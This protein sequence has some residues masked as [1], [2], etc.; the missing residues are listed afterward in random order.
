[1]PTLKFLGPAPGSAMIR[2]PVR[3]RKT[4]RLAV[5]ENNR[6]DQTGS[7]V[8]TMINS[9][10]QKLNS[11]AL[12]LR[13]DWLTY[14]SFAS[15]KLLNNSNSKMCVC[16]C[17]SIN[18][19]EIDIINQSALSF[20]TKFRLIIF[21]N[22]Q[23]QKMFQISKTKNKNK[24]PKK[25]IEKICRRSTQVA[26]ALCGVVLR[27]AACTRLKPVD[28]IEYTQDTHTHTRASLE[29]AAAAADSTPF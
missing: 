23:Q 5:S 9:V 4:R 16:V 21:S 1:M 27:P 22:K 12:S 2:S 14:P 25:W 11:M 24:K 26:R 17:A 15:S 8:L 10:Q 7:G 13:C 28:F 6:A 19:T 18:A 29:S 20:V 3:K